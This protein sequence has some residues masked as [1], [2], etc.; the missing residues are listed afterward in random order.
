[1][2]RSACRLEC[3]ANTNHNRSLARLCEGPLGLLACKHNAINI[4]GDAVREKHRLCILMI[5]ILL[6]SMTSL[7]KA[8]DLSDEERAKLIEDYYH[9]IHSTGIASDIEADYL[10][11]IVSSAAD[12]K[13]VETQSA[14]ERLSYELGD[15]TKDRVIRVEV[16]DAPFSFTYISTSEG[17][18][19]QR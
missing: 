1:M 18:F 10:T 16:R 4:G 6:L 9:Y 12:I 11:V 5:G 13:G 3:N 15:G 19:H 17:T 8:T 7:A 14:I 2:L